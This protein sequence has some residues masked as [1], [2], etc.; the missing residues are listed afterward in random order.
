MAETGAYSRDVIREIANDRDITVTFSEADL[1]KEMA[2]ADLARQADHVVL[3]CDHEG[4]EEEADMRTIFRLLNLRDVRTRYSLAFNITAEMRREQNQNLV[5][6]DD[7]TDFV[8]SS[9]MSSLFLAQLAE[10]PELAGVFDEILSNRGNE[11]YLKNAGTLFC[12]G[13]RTAAELRM[14]AL[15]QNY[16]MLGY[17]KDGESMFNP[18]LHDSVYLGLEDSVI[19]LGEN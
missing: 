1:N 4:D 19:V 15:R 3:L 2:L 10:S 8:V 18:G 16:I 11:L 7:H 14:T 13:E 6:S 9:N 12:T 17:I 5:V